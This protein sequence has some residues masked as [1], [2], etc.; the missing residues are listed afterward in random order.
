MTS[1]G[2]VLLLTCRTIDALRIYTSL[3]PN[4]RSLSTVHVAHTLEEVDRA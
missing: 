2:L 1:L 4:G 3:L